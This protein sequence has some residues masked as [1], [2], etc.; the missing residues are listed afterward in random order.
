MKHT[1]EPWTF[2]NIYGRLV[3][4]KGPKGFVITEVTNRGIAHFIGNEEEAIANGIL[5]AAAPKLLE[6]TGYLLNLLRILGC[7]EN[8][9]AII[10]TKELIKEA[11]E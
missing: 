8:D 7:T 2:V 10:K 11:T 9:D 6:H 1:P 5:I 3:V 4:T